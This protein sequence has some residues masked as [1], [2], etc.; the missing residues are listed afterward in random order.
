MRR[1]RQPQTETTGGTRTAQERGRTETGKR[2]EFTEVCPGTV[3]PRPAVSCN[4]NVMEE[5]QNYLQ[6]ESTRDN[7]L[8]TNISRRSGLHGRNLNLGGRRG[9]VPNCLHHNMETAWDDDGVNSTEN[10]LRPSHHHLGQHGRY[11]GNI[12]EV[13]GGSTHSPTR[14]TS[15]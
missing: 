11:H 10:D 1:K 13:C 4:P 8:N 5:K 12:Y 6:F 15:R 3:R 2:L 14:P 7:C 9:G